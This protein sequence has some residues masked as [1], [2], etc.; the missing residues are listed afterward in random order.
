MR[1]LGLDH[2]DDAGIWE[3]AKKNDYVLVTQDVDF[4]NLSALRGF[5][6]KI[7]W[8]RCGNRPT[9]FIEALLRQNHVAIIQF[10]NDPSVSCLEIGSP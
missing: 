8:L 6:P 4:S 3:Y 10:L 9:R 1:L 2:A 5:P 7:I